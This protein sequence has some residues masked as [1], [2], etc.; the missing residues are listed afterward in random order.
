MATDISHLSQQHKRSELTGH[1]L[2]RQIGH[3]VRVARKRKNLTKKELRALSHV[4]EK[5]IS[6]IEG[7]DKN[8]TIYSLL[9]V[10]KS[11]QIS[12]LYKRKKKK[13]DED[14]DAFVATNS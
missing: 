4:N 5:V 10:M 14:D 3:R 11:L 12:T 9:S 6:A 8:Y 1:A 2:L 13:S 7:G